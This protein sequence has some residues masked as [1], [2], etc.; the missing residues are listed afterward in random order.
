M[1]TARW[2]ETGTLRW[3][4]R[5]PNP[6]N[7]LRPAIARFGC[8]RPGGVPARSPA[9]VTELQGASRWPS[10]ERYKVDIRPSVVRRRVDTEWINDRVEAGER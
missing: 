2:I 7:I 9:A 5:F 10:W 1:R 3:E 4:G 6:G 8:T